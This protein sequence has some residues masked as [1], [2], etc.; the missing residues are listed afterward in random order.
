[1][2]ARVIEPTD[3]D[4]YPTLSPHGAEMLR[5]LREHPAAPY[6]RNQS[7]NRLYSEDI[8]RVLRFT[9]EVAAA[10][11]SLSIHHAP[12]WLEEF[13]ARTWAQVPAYRR[14]GP[15]PA[16][17]TDIA[18]ISRADFGHDIAAFV[19]D[20]VPVDRMIN[21]RTSG[22]TGH[23][24]LLASHPVVAAS[25]LAFHQR[26]LRRAGIE[27]R[28]GQGQVG[29]VLLGFQ[30]KCFTYVSVTPLREESGLVK[31]N[32]H[33]DDWRQP[34]DRARYLDALAAEVIAGDPLSFAELLTLPVTCTPRALLSTSMALLPGLRARLEAR[35]ACPVLDLYSMNEAGPIAVYEPAAQGHVLLQPRMMVEILDPLGH[36]LPIGE[37]GEITLTGGFNFCLPLLRYRTGDFASLAATATGEPVLK[38]LQGRPPIRFRTATGTWLNNIEITHAL[39]HTSLAQ[40]S[41]HQAADGALHFRSTGGNESELRSILTQLFGASLPV[42]IETGTCFENKV[43]QYTSDLPEAAP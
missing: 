28:H 31:L 26:A 27:L 1:M 11:L 18:P 6:F 24:L 22:T 40:F 41:L 25:Y 9:D 38:E 2:D 7:G 39:K 14:R 37:R 29:V 33:P 32:L 13:V 16:R 21:F 34:E 20:D 36:R 4:R 17:F 30:R 10:S 15:R 42:V 5:F 3:A 19:P 12:R 43:V 23:P 35:F 8:E